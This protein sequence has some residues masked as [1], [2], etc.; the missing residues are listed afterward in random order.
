MRSLG[1][2]PTDQ[3]LIEMIEQVDEDG[4]DQIDLNEFLRSMARKIRDTDTDEELNSGFKVFDVDQDNKISLEDLRALMTGLGEN[5][6]DEELED[7]I[8]VA[9]K[10]DDGLISFEEFT[11][12]LQAK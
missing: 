10:T 5:L 8:K 2:N 4:N 7:M 6:T 3:E 12:V 1:M 9:D 11:E